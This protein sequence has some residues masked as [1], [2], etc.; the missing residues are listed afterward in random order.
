[1][2]ARQFRR[3]KIIEDIVRTLVSAHNEGVTLNDN[4]LIIEV[5][6]KTGSSRN[7][8]I[9]YIKVA[10]YRFDEMINEPQGEQ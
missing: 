9:D 4:D 5:M 10:R 6:S 8:A 7:T 3:E 2:N 1:M